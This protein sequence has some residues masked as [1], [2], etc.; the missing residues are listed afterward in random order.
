[1]TWDPH[2]DEDS[3]SIIA[4][5]D[6]ARMAVARELAVLFGQVPT[7]S[8]W[9]LDAWQG[10]GRLLCAM[11]ILM[12]YDFTG[13]IPNPYM[14]AV[15]LA[16]VAPPVGKALQRYR[17]EVRTADAQRD[18]ITALQRE[19]ASIPESRLLVSLAAMARQAGGVTGVVA[20]AAAQV[21]VQSLPPGNTTPAEGAD[22][23]KGVG[24]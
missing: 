16:Y 21:Q 8:I 15:L 10:V 3:P 20:A 7:P 1:M 9:T 22:D 6:R 4:R 14:I 19:L 23:R 5:R 18:H 17:I 11:V 12:A 24:L 2:T 13:H